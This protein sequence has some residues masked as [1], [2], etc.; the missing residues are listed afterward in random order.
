MDM[1]RR[2]RQITDID[3]IKAIIA[4]C[5]VCRVAVKDSEGMYIFPISF[6][7]CFDN[8][9]KLTLYFHSAKEGRK[10]NAAKNTYE[11]A[12]EMDCGYELIETEGSACTYSCKYKSIVG[13]GVLSI[14]E[15]VEEKKRA[16]S[17]IMKNLADKDFC[18]DDKAAESVAVLKLSVSS[19]TAKAKL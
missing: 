12:F 6:G 3:A 7:Y 4:Q 1:R 15:D 8:E 17:L 2:D 19:F 11:A 10:V 5:D 14:A 9:D 13:N 16:L 18:F